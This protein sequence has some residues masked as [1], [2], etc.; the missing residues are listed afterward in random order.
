MV[1]YAYKISPNELETGKNEYLV[2]RCKGEWW[3][4]EGKIIGSINIPLGQLIRKARRGELESS[5]S[6]DWW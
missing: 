6:R 4:E 3:I 5:D 1:I 2:I